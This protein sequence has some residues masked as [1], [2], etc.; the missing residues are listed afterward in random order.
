[1]RLK[2]CDSHLTCKVANKFLNVL[3]RVEV[4]E[5]KKRRSPPYPCE[6]SVSVKENPDRKK[7]VKI[8]KL[9]SKGYSNISQKKICRNSYYKIFTKSKSGGG[10]CIFKIARMHLFTHFLPFQKFFMPKQGSKLENW[11]C[12]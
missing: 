12:Q 9:F 2:I 5:W 11:Q 3:E 7:K 8:K 1:M 6:S 4:V 10:V